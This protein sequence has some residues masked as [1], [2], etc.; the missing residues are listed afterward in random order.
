MALHGGIITKRPLC[1][2]ADGRLLLA[3]C[4]NDIRVYS[5]KSGEHIATLR[6]HEAEVTSVAQMDSGSSKLV[7]SS[8]LDGTLRQWD[9][10]EGTSLQTWTIGQPIESMVYSKQAGLAYV[11]VH[12]KRG[13]SGRVIPYQLP[14]GEEAP[15]RVKVSKAGRLVISASGQHV[16]AV[17]RNSLFVWAAG[18]SAAGRRAKP[19]NLPHTKPYTCAAFD[20]SDSIIAAGDASGRILIWHDFL[21]ALAQWASSASGS[22]SSSSAAPISATAALA[23]AA[24]EEAAGLAGGV[25]ADGL[26]VRLPACT[27]V[28]W[29]AHA[30]GALCFSMDGSQLLS[31]GQEG[32]LV[33][34]ALP[35]NKRTYLPRLGGPLCGITTSRADPARFFVAQSDNTVRLVNTAAMSV[36]LSIHGLRPPPAA[37]ALAAAGYGCCCSAAA[38]SPAGVVLQPGSGHLV[39][40]AEHANLQFFDV[41]RDRHVARLQV[42]PRNPVSLTEAASNHAAAAAAGVAAALLTQAVVLQAFTGDGQSLITVDV[43]PATGGLHSTA[44]AAAAESTL[45]FWDCS[46]SSQVASSGVPYSLNTNAD[47]PHRGVVTGLCCHPTQHMAV[48]TGSEGEFKVW[49]RS[50]VAAAQHKPSSS[51]SE[52]VAEPAGHWRCS[53]VGGYKGLGLNGC[54]FSQDGSLLAVAAGATATL[55]DPYENALVGTLVCPAECSSSGGSLRQLNFVHNSPHLVGLVGGGDPAAA[56][57]A[58]DGSAQ[59]QQQDQAQGSWGSSVV[60]WDLLNGAVSWYCNLPVCSLA[61]DPAYPLFAVGVPALASSSSS[62]AAG[63]AA[64]GSAA[65]EQ[66]DQQHQQQGGGK[67]QKQQ[68]QQQQQQQQEADKQQQGVKQQ[69][70]VVVFSPANPSPLFAAAVPDSSPGSLLFLHSSSSSSSKGAAATQQQQRMSQLLVLTDDRRYT[71][72]IPASAAAEAGSSDA[73]AAAAA[74]DAAVPSGTRAAM[75]AELAAGGDESALE[76]MFGKFEQPPAAAAAGGAAGAAAA[77][78]AVKAAV[79]QLFDAPSHVLPAPSTLCPT[80]LELLIGADRR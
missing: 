37:A 68:Q 24:V 28:H 63:A 26:A 44:A 33:M 57:A 9:I 66:Q 30:V 25:A 1:Y 72:L 39:L 29:H 10:Q 46:T 70:L 71:R 13:Q 45:R 35:S 73:A 16:A 6:G 59:Q 20:A 8:S 27:T 23:A 48:T 76:A 54:S 78:A 38:S 18:S 62:S 42:S 51:S 60:V 52:A 80:L 64:D 74:G 61:V 41:A 58:A 55:W 3:P 15:G 75:E 79:V 19:L 43:R 69:G 4:G 7:L 53:A 50:K 47:A 11:S 34:W 65:A 36:E 2:T 67:Q 40:P 17:D 5:S 21:R 32:V 31:G 12:Y 49:Q 14:S 77:E 22:S 56:A